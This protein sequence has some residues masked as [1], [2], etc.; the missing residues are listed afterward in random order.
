LEYSNLTHISRSFVFYILTD[1]QTEHKQNR[2]HKSYRK[3][4]YTKRTL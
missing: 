4:A 2:E 3:K 1:S